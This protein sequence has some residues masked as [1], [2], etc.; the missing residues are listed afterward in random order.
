VEFKIVRDKELAKLIF[1]QGHLTNDENKNNYTVDQF[2]K[3]WAKWIG[4]YV[5]YDDVHVVAF[6]GIRK[7]DNHE[8]RIFDRYFVMPDYRKGSLA[9]AE[10]SSIMVETLVNDCIENGYKPF[11]SI[12]TAKK[13]R[14]IDVAVLKFNK[15]TKDTHEF[16]VLHG[17]YCT[18][19]TSRDDPTCWQNIATISPYSISLEKQHE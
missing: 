12:Q 19:P 5:L 10:W 18:V 15:Y 14:A 2:E 11:F 17:L 16:K 13:R 6:C 7:F 9:H 8:A 3:A 4:F 1:I